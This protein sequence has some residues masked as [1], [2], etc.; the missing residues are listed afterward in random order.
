[1]NQPIPMTLTILTTALLI[2]CGGLAEDDDDS[3]GSTDSYEVAINH[4]GAGST[5]DL[6][7]V[8]AGDFEGTPA[9]AVPDVLDAAGVTAPEGS[10]Y[11][12]VAWDDYAKE[13]VTW[14]Q[15]EQAWLLLETG[16]L[17][18][19]ADLALETNFFVNGVVTIDLVSL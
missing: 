19:P 12:F 4:D 15:A 8:D 9:V 10:T 3:A 6:Y 5:V 7:D 1:M 14:E 2:G 17:Q 11:T 13:G 16:D 18:F